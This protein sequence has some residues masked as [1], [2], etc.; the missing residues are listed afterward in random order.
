MITSEYGKVEVTGALPEVMA[1]FGMIVETLLKS[2][3]ITKGHIE[4]AI[5]I[6]EEHC[7]RDEKHGDEDSGFIVK[8]IRKKGNKKK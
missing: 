4:Y 8:E 2:G 5:K 3:E 6:A 7:E 1:D